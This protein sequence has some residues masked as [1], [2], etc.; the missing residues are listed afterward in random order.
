MEKYHGFNTKKRK[1]KLILQISTFSCT[2]R[3]GTKLESK[4]EFYL[5]RDIYD[6]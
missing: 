6:V 3:F 1:Y 2:K 4:K 5:T